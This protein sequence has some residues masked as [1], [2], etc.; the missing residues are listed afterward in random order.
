V[1]CEQAGTEMALHVLACNMKRV[2]SILGGGAW[3]RRSGYRNAWSLRVSSASG[4]KRSSRCS[5]RMSVVGAEAENICST[6]VFR[7]LT[8]FGH[9]KQCVTI[10][11]ER[12]L[13]S[14]LL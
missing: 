4:T 10:V 14:R 12:Q 6:R 7:L 1:A 13:N 3:W 11:T 9:R 2:I 8:Q 5:H